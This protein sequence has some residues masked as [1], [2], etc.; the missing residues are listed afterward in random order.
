MIPADI[1]AEHRSTAQAVAMRPRSL[2]GATAIVAIWI[3][4]SV[5]AGWLVYRWLY[6]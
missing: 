1:M 6:R 4:L 2:A 5:G 3:A